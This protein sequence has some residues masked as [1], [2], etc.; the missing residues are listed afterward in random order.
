MVCGLLE[1]VGLVMFGYLMISGEHDVN[2]RNKQENGCQ[3][4]ER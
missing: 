2:M 3:S 4:R 1:L